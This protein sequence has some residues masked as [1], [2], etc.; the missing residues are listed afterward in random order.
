MWSML[1]VPEVAVE[2]PII[3]DLPSVS[4]DCLAIPHRDIRSEGNT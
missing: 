2:Y 3:V 1:R 4:S